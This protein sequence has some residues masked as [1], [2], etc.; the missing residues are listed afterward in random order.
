MKKLL[1]LMALLI[2][3][4]AFAG[5]H[6]TLF[7]DVKT[8]TIFAAK[9]TSYATIASGLKDNQIN[10]YET[11]VQNEVDALTSDPAKHTIVFLAKIAWDNRKT[12]PVVVGMVVY[13]DCMKN[14]GIS[15]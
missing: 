12:D 14:I 1:L 9:T 7:D 10:L 5:T 13:E 3:G 11:M 8:C 4:P 6:P 15:S 2:S